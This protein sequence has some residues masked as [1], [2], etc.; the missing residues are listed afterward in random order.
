MDRR[1]AKA[2]QVLGI[3]A[4]SDADAVVTAYRRLARVTH[5]DVSADPGAGDRFASLA[6]AYRL[7]SQA[8][9]VAGSSASADRSGLRCNGSAQGSGPADGERASDWAG[10]RGSVPDWSMR[11]GPIPRRRQPKAAPIVAG[12]VFISPARTGHGEVRDG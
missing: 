6:A 7:A 9:A 1:Q 3:P 8:A 10:G 12:P 11:L 5:P 4:D 2:F